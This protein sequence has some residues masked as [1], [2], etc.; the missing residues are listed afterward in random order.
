M[1]RCASVIHYSF[2]RAC[3]HTVGMTNQLTL[4]ATRYGLW[5][6]PLFVDKRE[7]KYMDNTAKA[8]LDG[9]KGKSTV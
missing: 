7:P 1:R 4:T 9:L 3:R 2:E 6:G 8:F 5:T